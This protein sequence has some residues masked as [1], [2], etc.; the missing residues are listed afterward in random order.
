MQSTTM[1]DQLTLEDLELGQ[2]FR[3]QSYA[4]DAAQI[5]TFASQFDPQP[6]HLDEE[7]AKKTFFGELVAS[8]WHVAAIT[9]RLLVASTPINGGLVGAGGDIR[10]LR[11]TRPGDTLQVE[12]EIVEIKPSQ[13]R[14]D[15]GTVTIRS[16][17]RNQDG[18]SVLVM[19]S[20][21]VVPTRSAV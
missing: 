19:N 2:V 12:T 9:M 1:S 13:S 10:W 8:G 18:K 21:L 4:I 15:R 11:P 5:K 7:L 6:F 17:T 16:T 14:T 3:S 20:R